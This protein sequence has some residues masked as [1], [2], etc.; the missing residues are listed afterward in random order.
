MN[1]FEQPR[2]TCSLTSAQNRITV[3]EMQ[4]GTT[5]NRTNTPPTRPPATMANATPTDNPSRT[6]LAAARSPMGR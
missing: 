6:T 1:S 2:A 5:Q 4:N 3:S